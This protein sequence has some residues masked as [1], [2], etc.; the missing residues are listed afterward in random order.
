MSGARHGLVAARVDEMAPVPRVTSCAAP[1]PGLAIGFQ[2][3]GA[4]ST[5][6]KPTPA[7]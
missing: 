4:F 6:F 7:R 5:A 1:V 2:S 3:P